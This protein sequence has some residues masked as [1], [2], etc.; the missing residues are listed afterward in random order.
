MDL[1]LVEE[2]T[3]LKKIPCIGFYLID[4]RHDAVEVDDGWIESTFCIG[5]EQFIVKFVGTANNCIG[6][7]VTHL[8]EGLVDA[9]QLVGYLV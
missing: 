8:Y 6:M 3:S 1:H 9:E 2:G 5:S 7:D 4:V